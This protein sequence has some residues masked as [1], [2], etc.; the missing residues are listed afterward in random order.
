[1]AGRDLQTLLAANCSSQTIAAVTCNNYNHCN[2]ILCRSCLSPALCHWILIGRSRAGPSRQA[3]G[4]HWIN[5]RKLY[6]QRLVMIRHG[7]IR[8]QGCS[9]WP[10]RVRD[11]LRSVSPRQAQLGEWRM[12]LELRPRLRCRS[13]IGRLPCCAL[14]GQAGGTRHLRPRDIATWRTKFYLGFQT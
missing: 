2:F 6:C 8:G 13:P 14:I 9:H 1:M 10:M 3:E 7:P 11:T 12:T 5:G 4:R